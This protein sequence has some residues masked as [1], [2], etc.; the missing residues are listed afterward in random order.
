MVFGRLLAVRWAFGD[1]QQQGG[2][3]ARLA[4]RVNVSEL[5]LNLVNNAVPKLLIGTNQKVC[6]RS[7]R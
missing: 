7:I 6:G 4:D 2:R 1:S 3:G 5:L